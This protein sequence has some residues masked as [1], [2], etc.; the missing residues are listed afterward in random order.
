MGEEVHAFSKLG[1]S[2][3]AGGGA[4]RRDCQCPSVHDARN[5][6]GQWVRKVAATFDDDKQSE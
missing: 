4:D 6:K 5:T 1:W 3:H 2:N